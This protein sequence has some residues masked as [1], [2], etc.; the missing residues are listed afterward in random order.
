MNK[1]EIMKT[2]L[3]TFKMNDDVARKSE[4]IK[5]TF[6]NA[7]LYE[8]F[9]SIADVMVIMGELEFAKGEK[10]GILQAKEIAIESGIEL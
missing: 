2:F 10:A 7:I 8:R 5:R 3:S 9:E 4:G 1:E 6:S